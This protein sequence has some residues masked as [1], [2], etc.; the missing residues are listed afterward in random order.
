MGKH[1]IDFPIEHR[2]AMKV[3]ARH[4]LDPTPAPQFP[5]I[6]DTHTGT[7]IRFVAM[8]NGMAFHKWE[9]IFH[10]NGDVD[11]ECAVCGMY[12]SAETQYVEP[13]RRCGAAV[14]DLYSHLCEACQEALNGK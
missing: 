2:N 4:G 14:A 10:D 9:P 11:Y 1:Y 6:I 3:L 5:V 12:A 8:C 13:C 7:P